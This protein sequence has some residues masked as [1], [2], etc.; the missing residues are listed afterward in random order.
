MNFQELTRL[1]EHEKPSVRLMS[2]HVLRMVDEVQAL[3]AIRS[4]IPRESSPKIRGEL[5]ATGKLS[6][7]LIAK[8]L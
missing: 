2:I 7:A 5:Q 8:W 1:L 6:D 4:R 3:D